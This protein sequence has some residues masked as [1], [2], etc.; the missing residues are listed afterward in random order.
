M[1]K[2]LKW[3]VTENS[4]SEKE[5]ARTMCL[6]SNECKTSPVS[7][8]HN[9][10]QTNEHNRKN[11]ISMVNKAQYATLAYMDSHIW[12]ENKKNQFQHMFLCNHLKRLY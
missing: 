12:R 6:C 11:E 2:H 8:S 4:T 5:Q 9:F 1:N 7:A 3:Q 10:L